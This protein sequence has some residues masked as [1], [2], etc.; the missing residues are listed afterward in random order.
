MDSTQIKVATQNLVTAHDRLAQACGTAQE[1]T[2]REE[3]EAASLAVI[4][5][6]AHTLPAREID[7]MLHK[8]QERNLT[9]RALGAL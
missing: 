1:R 9:L 3:Y 8:W 4:E 5:A 6:Y 7:R 2:M